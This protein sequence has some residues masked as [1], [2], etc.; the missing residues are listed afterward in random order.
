M[1]ARRRRKVAGGRERVVKVKLTD[2]EY[3]EVAARAAAVGLTVPGYLAVAGQ[4]DIVATGAGGVSQLQ[5][6]ALAAELYAL[7]R[8]LRGSGNN[9]N[10][11]T[12]TTH[13][14]GE[15]QVEARHHAN[16]IAQTMP[17]LDELLDGIRELL[18]W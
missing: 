6:R 2:D 11:L 17:R 5:L 9:L 4:Q 16:R 12:R 10:Q 8:I 7:K 13:A 14:T 15:F 18:P 3:A 1:R